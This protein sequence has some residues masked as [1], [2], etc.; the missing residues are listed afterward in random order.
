MNVVGE[1]GIEPPTSFLSGKRS[2]IEPL[3]QRLYNYNMLYFSELKGKRVYTEDKIFVGKLK[4]M[5]FQVSET[6]Q[7]TKFVI[8]TTDDQVVVPAAFLKKMDGDMIISKNFQADKLDDNE[9]YLVNNLLDNQIIDITGD[10]VVRV[11]DVAIQDKPGYFIAGVDIGILGILR[12]FGLEEWVVRFLKK[13]RIKPTSQFLSWADI[14]PLELTRGHV[15]IKTEQTKL[16][17]IPPEDLADYLEKTNVSNVSHVLN[18][19]DEKVAAEVISN[20]NIN[21]QTALFKQFPSDKAAKVMSRID[22]EEAV[23]ILLT[24]SRKKR[25]KIMSFLGDQVYKE[26]EYLLGLS[27]TPIGGILS[28]EFLT[29]QSDDR[30]KEVI[31]RVQKTTGDFYSL[32]YIYVVNQENQLVGVFSLHELLLQSPETPVYKFMTQN[33]SVIHLSTP[34]VIVLRKII[35]Y[36]LNALPVVDKD[37]HILGVVT[38]DDVI[39]L[40][41]KHY[42]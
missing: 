38:F 8:G 2:T 33:L 34:E 16:E 19:L 30:V 27:K 4:D 24:L 5:I 17:K 9:L 25:E 12:W 39:D 40:F 41:L 7:I 42:E 14:H 37:R 36:K 18:V 28:T 21:Y 10:K 11:N 22:P 3:A 26:I 13:L 23:D 6:P 35:K 31:D 32:H 29:I 20:L 15:K 1:G